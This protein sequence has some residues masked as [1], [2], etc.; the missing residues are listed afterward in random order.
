[1]YVCYVSA[2]GIDAYLFIGDYN[3]VSVYVCYITHL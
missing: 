3:Y 1:M 2:L